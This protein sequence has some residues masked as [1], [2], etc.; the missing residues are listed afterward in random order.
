MNFDFLVLVLQML[1]VPL[2]IINLMLLKKENIIQIIASHVHFLEAYFDKYRKLRFHKQHFSAYAASSA[3]FQSRMCRC[4]TER[5]LLLLI[6][7]TVNTCRYLDVIN[8]AILA[9]S[10]SI[11]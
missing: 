6:L 11:F 1:I 5:V 4:T 2:D 3:V 7:I 9:A 10:N 8:K